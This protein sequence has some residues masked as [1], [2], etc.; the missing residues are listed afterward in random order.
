MKFLSVRSFF[1]QIDLSTALN[2]IE[3]RVCDLQKSYIAVQEQ[4]KKSQN[5]ADRQLD[6]FALQVIDILDMVEVAQAKLHLQVESDS[7]LVIKK[8]ERK[9]GHLLGFWKIQE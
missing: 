8:I 2:S 4:L 3:N 7:F 6:E 1:M 5:K 9:L